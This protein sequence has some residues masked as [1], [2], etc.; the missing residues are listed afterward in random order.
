MMWSISSI[1][2]ADHLW[3]S[4]NYTAQ[5]V[6]RTQ[7]KEKPEGSAEPFGVQRMR[8]M[9]TKGHGEQARRENNQSGRNIHK[10]E[11]ER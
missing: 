11:R 6:E 5:D 3:R 2:R 9:A 7:Q 1:R 10:P 4:E 8:N